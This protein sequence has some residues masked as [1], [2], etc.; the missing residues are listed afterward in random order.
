VSISV[1]LADDQ[2][3]LRLGFRMIIEAEENLT[4]SGEAGD[5]DEAIKL[6]RQ[7]RRTSC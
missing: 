1:L 6:A 7:H 4:V 2:P 5:G 3:L